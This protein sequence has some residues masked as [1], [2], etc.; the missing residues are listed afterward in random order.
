MIKDYFDVMWGLEIVRFRKP[1]VRLYT[2]FIAPSLSSPA[3]GGPLLVGDTGLDLH[4]ARNAGLKSCW[5]AYG[6]GDSEK[7]FALEP[8]FVI[9]DIKELQTVL[10]GRNL[11]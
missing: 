8:D 6:Y 5:A 10:Q 3:A 7:C 1:D 9:A 2:E 4:F 11:S